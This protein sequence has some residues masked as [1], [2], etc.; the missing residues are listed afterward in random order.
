MITCPNCGEELDDGTIHCTNCGELVGEEPK[1]EVREITKTITK[2]VEKKVV[3]KDAVQKSYMDGMV[4][5][6]KFIS[7]L[8]GGIDFLDDT[9]YPL[10]SA[11]EDENVDVVTALLE[12]GAD[13]DQA[14]D[15]GDTALMRAAANGY[16]KLV[17]TLIDAGADVDMTNNDDES[18]LSLARDNGNRY[19]V[20]L[21][22]KAGAYEEDDDDD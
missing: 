6:F 11:A 8:T 16:N 19:I 21:L 9:Y 22:R 13:V 10:V 12:A 7:D 2:T 20:G 5:A 14:D 4:E 1:P 17:K 3:D 15:D 18:A